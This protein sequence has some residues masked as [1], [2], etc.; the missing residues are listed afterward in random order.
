MKR[1]S[2]AHSVTAEITTGNKSEAA[3]LLRTDYKTLHLKMKNCGVDA[4][5]F[6]ELRAGDSAV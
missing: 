5:R 1:S 4:R 3:R 2:P 6:R